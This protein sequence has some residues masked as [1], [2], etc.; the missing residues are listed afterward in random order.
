MTWHPELQ[1]LVHSP[2]EEQDGLRAAKIGSLPSTPLK[3]NATTPLGLPAKAGNQSEVRVSFARPAGAVRLSV[4]VMVDSSRKAA[5][6]EFFIEYV[7]AKPTVS[8]G[9]GGTTDV[10]Q[11]LPDDK[12]IE[13]ILYVDNTFTEAF[14][15]GGRVAMTVVTPTSGGHDDVTLGASQPGVSASATAWSVG[16]I[17]VSPEVVKYTPRRG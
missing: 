4:N 15:Q 9:S 11:L 10:L 14:W 2:V 16:S 8:V 5:G 12:T 1:Q 17:W 6:T 7:P 3:P 13:L